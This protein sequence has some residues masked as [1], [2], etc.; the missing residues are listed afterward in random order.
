MGSPD[1]RYKSKHHGR[2]K[3]ATPKAAAAAAAAAAKQATANKAAENLQKKTQSNDEYDTDI[4]IAP[5]RICMSMVTKEDNNP[6]LCDSCQ[7]WCHI[8][9]TDLDI[10]ACNFLKEAAE[11]HTGIKWFCSKCVLDPIPSPDFFDEVTAKQDDKID[12]LSKMF[13]HMQ[14]KMDS[15][16]TQI[17]TDR[18]ER[19]NKM[20]VHVQEVLSDHREIDEKKCNMMV[21]N[22]PE[23]DKDI[24]KLKELLAYVNKD[25]NID[26]LSSTNVSRLGKPPSN[27]GKPRPMKIVF[28]NADT[29]WQFIKRASSLKNSEQFKKV[30]LSLDKTTKERQE[31]MALRAK[32]QEEK[33]KRPDDDLVI[34]R[35]E[36]VRRVDIEN[37]KRQQRQQASVGPT[38]G[39]P[40]TPGH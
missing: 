36:I 2:Q 15:V 33:N 4:N 35:K 6:M 19:E 32:L 38:N 20:G 34:F 28:E 30:G 39:D 31:D 8:E 23:S 11:K 26:N 13:E 7:N 14:M 29:K 10:E 25:V 12:K 16:L 21:F 24:E 9:C 1:N 22:F 17:G 27:E 18:V 37:I 3:K 40:A 5:C